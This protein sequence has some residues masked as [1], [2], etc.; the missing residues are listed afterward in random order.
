SVGASSGELYD[1]D[2][3]TPDAY[4]KGQF[5]LMHFAAQHNAGKLTI[6][7][8]AERGAHH[9]A[10]QGKVALVLHEVA[11]KPCKLTV[12]GRV[13][14]FAWDAEHKAVAVKLSWDRKQARTLV[15]GMADGGG[16]TILAT[17]R[18]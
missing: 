17:N 12:D 11:A 4:A 10:G 1:D 8:K 3:K 6:T 2:G 18:K 9:P 16:C 5:E 14:P 13:L 7:L 15:F